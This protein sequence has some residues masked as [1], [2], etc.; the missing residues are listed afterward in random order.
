ML[1]DIQIAQKSKMKPIREIAKKIG[2]GDNFL[3]LYGNY[4]AKLTPEL[5]GKIK[6]RPEKNQKSHQRQFGRKRKK[7]PKKWNQF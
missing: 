3:E 1:S 2:I 5:W 7:M 4:K 6:K